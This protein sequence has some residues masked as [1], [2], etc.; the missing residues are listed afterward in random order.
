MKLTNLIKRLFEREEKVSCAIVKKVPINDIIS[1]SFVP[2]PYSNFNRFEN[3]LFFFDNNKRVSV[4]TK[5]RNLKEDEFIYII[6]KKGFFGNYT[7]KNYFFSHL[8]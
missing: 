5:E 1:P 8:H 6:Y 7:I 3:R 4:R 2:V